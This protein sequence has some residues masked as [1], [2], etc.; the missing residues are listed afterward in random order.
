MEDQTRKMFTEHKNTATIIHYYE[1]FL[2]K[3]KGNL[4]TM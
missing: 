3:F 1:A 2:F 4:Q